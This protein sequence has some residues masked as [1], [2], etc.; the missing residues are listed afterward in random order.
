MNKM[1]DTL[2][3]VNTKE[4]NEEITLLRAREKIV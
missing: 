4:L 3:C 2:L 1:D